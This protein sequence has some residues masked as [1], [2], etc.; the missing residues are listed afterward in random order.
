MCTSTKW[1]VVAP[2]YSVLLVCV[3]KLVLLAK[4]LTSKLERRGDRRKEPRL[5]S[6]SG[7]IQPHKLSIPAMILCF[8]LYVA[9]GGYSF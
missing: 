3:C 4:L 7:P 6:N 9:N 5:H 1:M 8:A 2:L